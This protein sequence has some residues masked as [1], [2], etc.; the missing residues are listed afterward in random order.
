MPKRSRK[1]PP[2]PVQAAYEAV[3]ALTGAEDEPQKKPAKKNPHAVALGRKG[4][5]KGGPAR[6]EKLTAKQRSASAR[7]A[8][9]ARWK[10]EKQGG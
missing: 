6:A 8:A 5:L 7:K 1:P 9:K 4:G 2:D 10:Q 3:Q